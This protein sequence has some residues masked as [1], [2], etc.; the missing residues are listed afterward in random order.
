MASGLGSRDERASFGAGTA[1]A[2]SDANTERLERALDTLGQVLTTFGEY[3]FDTDKSRADETRTTFAE[4]A[5]TLLLGVRREG[6]PDGPPGRRDWGSALKLLR[7]HR[8]EE[9]NF[10][11]RGIGNLRQALQAFASCLSA[12]VAEEQATDAQLE[13]RLGA[14]RRAIQGNDTEAIR[15]EAQQMA[16]V[17]E[18]SI[19]RRR[20]RE[21]RQL[22]ELGGRVQTLRTEL[23]TVRTQATLDSLTQLY[24][25]AALDQEVEKVAALGLLLGSMPCLLLVDVD[26]FKTIN[27]E[28]GHPIGDQVLKGVAENLVR[29]FLRKEDFVARYGGEEFAIVV[30]EG[31]LEKVAD[32]AER[33]REAQ[34]ARMTRAGEDEI[35]ASISIGIASLRPGESTASWLQRADAALY[36]AK[37]GG[38]NRSSVAE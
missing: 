7:D 3:A 10:V 12:S 1:P 14:L 17:V 15:N 11:V 2:H 26:H 29:H 6:D 33:M 16:S 27:D 24:N 35:R 28:Y 9:Q 37:H 34:S 31:A 22:S 18:S 21:R 36:A 25:R 4:L 38:R 30:R 20:E 19:D 23:E 32:R 5:R 13:R 8:R